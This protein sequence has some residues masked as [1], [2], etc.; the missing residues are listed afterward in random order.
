MDVRSDRCYRFD[1]DRDT[2]WSTIETVDDY[3]GWWPWLRR[4]DANGLVQ[5]DVWTCIVQPPLPYSLR[6]TIALDHVVRGHVADASL[7]GDIRGRARLE[8]A[9]SEGGC[10]ARLV[11]ALVPANGF[12]RTVA[13]LAHPIAQFGHDWVLDTGARQF[14]ARYCRPP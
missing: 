11:S 13:A 3:R 14:N 5:G 8:L 4:F 2:L 1:V 7:D 10:E 6:F 9:D 12:L